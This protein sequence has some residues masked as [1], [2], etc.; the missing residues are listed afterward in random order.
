MEAIATE[1][2][3]FFADGQYREFTVR[4]DP[5]TLDL[6]MPL[7]QPLPDWVRLDFYQCTNCGLQP[8]SLPYCPAALAI[9]G[10]VDKFADVQSHDRVK[11]TVITPD[12]VMQ[13]D[14]TVQRAVGSM[15]GLMLATCGCP[16]TAFFK[17]MAR[18]HLPLANEEETTFRAASMYLL[19][20]YFRDK[21][22]NAA[23]YDFEGLA[24]LYGDLQMIN[25]AL[26]NRIRRASETDSTVNAIVLLD[27]YAKAVPFHL[28]D[29]LKKIENYFISYWQPS[30]VS[31]RSASQ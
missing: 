4:I 13:Q 11:M 25:V 15:M 19:A 3:L 22:G 9:S 12:R 18:F 20:Q 8:E 31:T 7:P 17:P 6:I 28:T 2:R 26:A 14:T 27:M 21:K 5:L 30:Q 24:S 23:H 16:H 29:S 1:Y 10:I